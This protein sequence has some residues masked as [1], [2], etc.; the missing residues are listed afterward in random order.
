YKVTVTDQTNAA[1]GMDS[2]HITVIAK[3]IKPDITTVGITTFCEGDRVQ[4]SSSAGFSWQWSNGETTR[5]IYAKTTGSYTVNVID[6]FGCASEPSDAEPVTVNPKPAT[7]T[8]LASGDTDICP[9]DSVDLTSSDGDN[10]IWST[11]ES[12]K[13]IRIKT[14]GN[15]YVQTQ[16]ADGCKS[17]TSLVTP[18]TI[19]TP[20]DAP[21]ITT[22]GPTDFCLGDS[23]DLESSAGTTWLWSNGETT[24]TIRVKT[25]GSYSAQITDGTGCLSIPSA[26]TDITTKTPP[27]APMITT[28]GPTDFCP[29]DSVDLESSA[30]T[31]WLWSNGE[32]TRTI[33]VKTAGSYTAQI[34]DG[35]GCLSIPS[36]D[37]DITLY[38][39]PVA[40]VITSGG[41]T[42]I[43]E[44]DS[45]LLSSSAGTSYLW[46]TGEI[47]STIYAKS[48]GSYTVQVSNSQGCWS[49]LSSPINIT[50]QPAP[51]KPI[52]S[53]TGNT[54][55]CQGDSLVLTSSAADSYLWSNSG[56]TP[57]II[58][59]TADTYS[60]RVASANGCLSIPSDA[61]NITVN[62][63]PVKPSISGD[64][65]YCTGDSV[66]LSGPAASSYI[67]STGES[68]QTIFATSG[69]FTLKVG[70]AKGCMSP[71]SDPYSVT[72][73]PLPAKPAI[74]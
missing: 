40:P 69:S 25:A 52:I 9:G 3:P 61:V 13:T 30:G 31:T 42:D 28:S 33:R 51:I 50:T 35:T 38:P 2:I 16:T 29:G 55:F 45:L 67:W 32:T 49:P 70:D 23:V 60:V 37:T 65:E 11:G 1:V 20:P 73:N 41:S 15:Y 22:S 63:L 17:D 43:C 18:V 34:T 46:S 4:L 48:A 66:Q 12:T 7:P 59:R 21:T 72:E 44:N 26:D 47:S 27:D 24:R 58:V 14:A 5:V 62:S 64:N 8:M 68:T 71:I 54:D 10:Y 57:A 74:S 36:A 56:T 6:E 19:K 39:V 53:F